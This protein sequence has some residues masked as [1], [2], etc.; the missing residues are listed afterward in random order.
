MAEYFVVVLTLA[1]LGVA[2]TEGLRLV[3]MRLT[4]WRQVR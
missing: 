3:E 2:V 1:L 4:R